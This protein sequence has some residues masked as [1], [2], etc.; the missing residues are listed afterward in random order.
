MSQAQGAAA[1][2][3]VSIAESINMLKNGYTR[4]KKDEKEPGKSIQSFYG[5]NGVEAKTL[6]GHSKLRNLKTITPVESSLLI[7][8]DTEVEP[9]VSTPTP[10]APYADLEGPGNS[11]PEVTGEP[12]TGTTDGIT[13]NEV[14]AEAGVPQSTLFS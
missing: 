14:P 12:L 5:L 3:T 8:D 13:A 6:F 10:E 7:I 9:T 2:K 4:Y 11:V 1:Q